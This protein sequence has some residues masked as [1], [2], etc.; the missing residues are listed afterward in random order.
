MLEGVSPI[1]GQT[2]SD[3]RDQSSLC[4]KPKALPITSA[5]SCPNNAPMARTKSA[6]LMM[7]G[8]RPYIT[9]PKTTNLGVG[10]S[11]RSG[12]ANKIKGLAAVSF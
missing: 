5:V 4:I 7:V 1:L 2:P 12:R 10:R 8:N 6:S 9:E 11:N 3:K